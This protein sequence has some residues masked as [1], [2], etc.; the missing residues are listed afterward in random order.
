M[1]SFIQIWNKILITVASCWIFYVNYTMMHGS[2]NIKCMS[3]CQVNITNDLQ[4][5]KYCRLLPTAYT[6]ARRRISKHHHNT[7]SCRCENANTQ[8]VSFI[9]SAAALKGCR[10]GY[11]LCDKASVFC[12]AMNKVAQCTSD[13][14]VHRSKFTGV[15]YKSL[16]NP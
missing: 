6:A 8:G 12:W 10:G 7:V 3:L 1:L 4:I 14:K 2:T 9:S 5:Y 16:G 11:F 15:I 13:T